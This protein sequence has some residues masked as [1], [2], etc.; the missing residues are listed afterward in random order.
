MWNMGLLGASA[1]IAAGAYELIES[2]ILTS[3]QASVTFSSIPQDYK[4][5]Q[6][7]TVSRSSRSGASLDVLNLRINS[8]SN[9]NY[10][11][12]RLFG[13]GSSVTSNSHAIRDRADTSL[14]PA[15]N[16]ATNHFGTGVIDLL[17]YTSTNKNTTIRGLS[18]M[19][20]VATYSESRLFSA[21]YVNTSA[22]SSILLYANAGD[23]ITGSR[24]S[25]Y[26]IKG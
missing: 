1:P 21:L 9:N 23:L 10:V 13:N 15:T 4:H 16:S 19:V 22:V 20:D 24:F 25:L 7:R 8:D 17:D 3:Q 6:I 11:G 26:G 5:L 12:H 2:T 14:I 18:G